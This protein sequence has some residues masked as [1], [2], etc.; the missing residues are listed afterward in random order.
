MLR[1][2]FRRAKLNGFAGASPAKRPETGVGGVMLKMLKRVG[3]ALLGLVLLVCAGVSAYWFWGDGPRG[4][5]AFV[6]RTYDEAIALYD[7][8]LAR[9]YW[10]DSYRL[11]MLLRRGFSHGEL[12]Q[13]AEA[14]TDYD[15][16][17]VIR[18][19]SPE[20]HT[21]R[22]QQHVNVL[23]WEAA[24][25]EYDTALTL[26]PTNNYLRARRAWIFDQTLDV[27]RAIE[28][29]RALRQVEPNQEYYYKREA[30]N[31][32]RKGETAKAAEVIAAIPV[33]GSYDVNALVGRAIAYDYF[34]M[35]GLGMPDYER[36]LRISP[37]SALVL[38]SRGITYGAMNKHK[39]A[40][41]DYNRAIE[42]EPTSRHIFYSRGREQYMAGDY[43]AALADMR[44]AVSEVPFGPYSLIW[45]HLA[46]TWL[47]EVDMKAF[48]TN[49]TKL[50]D[51]DW[52]RPIN[53]YLLGKIDETSLRK[54]AIEKASPA[55]VID[56]LCEVDYY[57]GA[58]A[59]AKGNKRTALPLIRKAA[60]TCPPGYV[61]LW[62]AR[63]NLRAMGE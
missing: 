13:D 38:S 51:E 55:D 29:Y 36:A 57:L 8:E 21:L 49:L 19:D 26:D 50:D 58:L 15:A 20:V 56:H 16:A 5:R 1:T 18:P 24:L 52:P 53:E 32:A 39:L 11:H 25:R 37:R 17:L 12:N 48:E 30:Y 44:F 61:E 43:R 33:Y 54:A 7:K 62:A 6:A 28:A 27:D 4:D 47:G 46:E 22:G 40:M 63:R 41:D 60:K 23:E 35:S 9:G 59:L 31:L 2:F 3:I 10:W 42:I 45:I 34:S 14:A